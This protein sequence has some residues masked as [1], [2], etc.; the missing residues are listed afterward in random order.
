VPVIPAIDR[1]GGG[2]CQSRHVVR[3]L[4]VI[5]GLR[6]RH[7]PAEPSAA[8]SGAAAAAGGEPPA[9]EPALSG[10]GSA[11]LRAALLRALPLVRHRA[12][13]S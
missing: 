6:R 2:G 12:C 10:G 11:R 3:V 8:E 7:V 5:R 4:V 13:R 1:S 9:A